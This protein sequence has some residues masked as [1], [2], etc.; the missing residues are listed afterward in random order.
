MNMGANLKATEAIGTGSWAPT[1]PSEQVLTEPGAV[2]INNKAVSASVLTTPAVTLSHSV[3]Q[4]SPL[5]Q[6]ALQNP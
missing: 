2:S 6:L 3:S 1:E 4:I 5:T